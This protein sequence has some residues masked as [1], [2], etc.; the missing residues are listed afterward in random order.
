MS[1]LWD[2]PLQVASPTEQCPPDWLTLELLAPIDFV[3]QNNKQKDLW[4]ITEQAGQTFTAGSSDKHRVHHSAN[5]FDAN[6]YRQC[7]PATVQITMWNKKDFGNPWMGPNVERTAEGYL[8]G[9][10]AHASGA[11]IDRRGLI[12]TNYHVVD[13]AKALYA[14]LP[15]GRS[16]KLKTIKTDES[17]D[18]ALVMIEK[19]KNNYPCMKLAECQTLEPG[20]KIWRFGHPRAVMEPCMA[21]GD[22]I[23]SDQ[24]GQWEVYSHA[25]SEPGDSGSP[26]VN[27][28]GEIVGIHH[29]ASPIGF[30]ELDE[31]GKTVQSWGIE[32]WRTLYHVLPKGHSL[33]L[34]KDKGESVGISAKYVKLLLDSVSLE[35]K[36]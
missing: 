1:E 9:D 8:S 21:K 14:L 2:K 3:R 4:I 5:S 16:A 19:S 12:V 18:L 23:N 28:K 6:L 36:Y 11:I 27:A 29:A 33:S 15:D 31:K 34:I 13:G 22:V 24:G 25:H 10:G 32:V 26:M 17:H 35:K 30:K 20:T 7:V